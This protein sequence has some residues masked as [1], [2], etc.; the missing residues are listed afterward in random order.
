MKD[1]EK[2]LIDLRQERDSI[3]NKIHRLILFRTKHFMELDSNHL[4]LL[5]IQLNVMRTYSETLSARI[6][7][8]E[9][10]LDENN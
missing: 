3:N 1:K 7:L 10:G 2:L 5:D 8:V 9:G 6:V 4:C